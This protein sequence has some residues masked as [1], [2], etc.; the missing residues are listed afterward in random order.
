M[1]NDDSKTTAVVGYLLGAAALVLLLGHFRH[2]LREA[3][4]APPHQPTDVWPGA[5]H[6]LATSRSV[7]SDLNFRRAYVPLESEVRAAQGKTTKLNST[8][9]VRNTSDGS[10]LYLRRVELFGADGKRH[11]DYLSDTIELAPFATL[12]FEMVPPSHVEPHAVAEPCASLATRTDPCAAPA[13][14]FVVEW[15]SADG[16]SRPLIETIM[17][18]DEAKF[19]H[20]RQAR[21]LGEEKAAPEKVRSTVNARG[22][23][24]HLPP[25]AVNL[26]PLG[27]ERA[28]PDFELVR[29][30]S[31]YGLRVKNP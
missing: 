23:G 8:L 27:T 11:H 4:F 13:T 12:H 6:R 18:D 14:H 28:E 10:P 31:N 29:F 9:V 20:A 2:D 16:I 7:T 5:A 21:V 15:A 24:T 19:S 17:V 26:A 30:D 22:D 3:L 1:R 25:L